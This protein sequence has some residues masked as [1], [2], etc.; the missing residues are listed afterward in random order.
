M[1]KSPA[2]NYKIRFSDCD[3][4]GHL[5]NARYLDYFLH[6]REE[7]LEQHY[8]LRLDSYYKEGTSWVVGGHQIAYLKPAMYSE[9]VAIESRLLLAETNSLLIEMVM[10]DH[11]RTHLKS[12]LW[13]RFVPIDI[14]TGKRQ[15]HPESFMEFAKSIEMPLETLIDFNERIAQLQSGFILQK[16]V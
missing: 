9:N 15:S 2:S 1:E 3:L 6:A 14:K 7:H 8:G 5:N 10:T 11:N 16:T 13:T 4:F 12:V